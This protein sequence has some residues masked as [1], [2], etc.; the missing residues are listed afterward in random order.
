MKQQGVHAVSKNGLFHEDGIDLD[1]PYLSQSNVDG[2]P[3][4]WGDRAA[5]NLDRSEGPRSGSDNNTA[6][7]QIHFNVELGSGNPQEVQIWGEQSQPHHAGA[8]GG[9]LLILLSGA[10]YDHDYWNMPDVSGRYSFVQAAKE[11]GFATLNLDRLGLGQS[12][13]PSADQVSLVNEAFETHQIIDQIKAGALGHIYDNIILVGHSLGSG[14]A[15]QEAG[16]FNDVDGV[17]LTGFT[18]YAGPN[19]PMVPASLVPAS[20]DS[21]LPLDQQQPGY[22]TTA[23]GD[24]S[25]FYNVADSTPR[26]IATDEA[27]KQTVTTG[28]L[29]DFVRILSDSA[30]SNAIKAPVLSIFGA[31]DLLFDDPGGVRQAL[32]EHAWFN[33]ASSYQAIVVPAAGHD[34]QLQENARYS[35]NEIFNW[36][37]DVTQTEGLVVAGGNGSD[38][39]VGGD[40]PNRI[41]GGAGADILAGGG[42][43]VLTGGAG[44]D[45]FVFGSGSGKDVITDFNGS[46]GDRIE[47]DGGL[48]STVGH[49]ASG[50]T[51]LTFDGEASSVTLSGVSEHQ[52]HSD[53]IV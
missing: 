24:R 23:A 41:V 37:H 45:T 1:T 52:F 38:V 5:P 36:L 43:D 17:V 10:T 8:T 34:L 39:L 13:K 18:H 26:V 35:D 7:H 19:F 50:N 47:L 16:T 11:A 30:I 22:L 12:S 27:N 46:Q 40:Q 4:V 31:Q 3:I 53:W 15:V 20:T 21:N 25:L 48:H 9:T 28:E 42:N 44:A 29:G 6:P 2:N 33:G 49:D 14:L 51:V 32:D